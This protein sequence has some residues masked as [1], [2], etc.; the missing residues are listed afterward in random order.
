MLRRA[1]RFL[2]P[3]SLLPTP[4][5]IQGR[6]FARNYLL[7]V[8]DALR[9]T[10]DPEAP[11]RHLNISGGGSFAALGAHNVMLCRTLGQLR[12]DEAVLDV[13]C[14][15]GRTATA[16][17]NFLSPPGRY[18]GFDVIAFAIRWCREH[19]GKRHANFTFVHA[20][21]RN[22][23]YN[24]R[25][26]IAADQYVFPFP[27]AEFTFTIAT[28]VFTHL[29]PAT[30]EQYMREVA[31]TLGR[32]GR[33][34]STWFLLDDTTE[35][36]L[37]AGK[38]TMQFAHRFDNHAQGSLVSPEQKVAYRRAYVEDLFAEAGLKI[39]SISHGGWSG[40]ADSIDSGQDVIVAERV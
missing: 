40:A 19:I 20:N 11:P 25:G 16:L 23:L 12:S 37:A 5:R 30:T 18:A 28:S 15:I 2:V 7:D 26:A 34:L 24:P 31:R 29:L 9:G 35:A 33:F 21:V 36:A 4:V 27:S 38:S 32:K 17:G 1:I 8:W 6:S 39:T 10:G 13:G 14:G 3:N 22:A